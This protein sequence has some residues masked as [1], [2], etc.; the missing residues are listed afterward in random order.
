MS[1]FL[2]DRE[3]KTLKYVDSIGKG[4]RRFPPSLHIAITDHCFNHCPMCGHWRRK[5]KA[6]LPWEALLKFLVEP[7]ANGLQTI[8]YS[9]GDPM[10]YPE[11]NKLLGYHN[12]GAGVGLDFGIVTSGYVPETVDI[13]DLAKVRWVRV[14][15]DAI[16]DKAYA[17]CRG[18]VVTFSQVDESI[19]RMIDNDV[20]VELNV[21]VHK[22]N[23]AHIDEIYNYADMNNID[24]V[25]V[26]DAY[27]HSDEMLSSV[28]KP[29]CPEP[30]T[31]CYASLFQL[32]IDAHGFIYPC[33]II[34]GD[35]ERQPRGKHI[36]HISETAFVAQ[37]R[38]E[39]FSYIGFKKIS[40]I[41]NQICIPRLNEINV[42]MDRRR[43][44][45]D[46]F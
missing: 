31:T 32:F 18:G 41:C 42:L 35:T 40:D 16:G 29:F 15:L 1:T 45:R 38:A 8:C 13:K 22:D 43:L 11:I 34:G 26:R 39:A 2:T 9:G 3:V 6:S 14:S 28:Q 23:I 4:L 37:G 33:C 21:T 27:R 24:K 25:V 46:F 5:E 36:A 10:A 12:R 30:V 17:K 7:I 19:K 20:N 44:G